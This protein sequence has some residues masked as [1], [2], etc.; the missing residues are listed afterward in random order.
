MVLS[1]RRAAGHTGGIDQ[2]TAR[3]VNANG[4]SINNWQVRRALEVAAY[5]PTVDD[6]D[7]IGGLFDIAAPVVP[8]VPYLLIGWGVLTPD[9]DHAVV[10]QALAHLNISGTVSRQK[11]SNTC[12]YMSTLIQ[13]RTV[14][15]N[16]VAVGSESLLSSEDPY[17]SCAN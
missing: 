14:Y 2:S 8:V 17:L 9:T 10:S 12:T 13:A 6:Y 7:P 1:A 4:V 11:D 15:W 5:V 16:Y 3:M